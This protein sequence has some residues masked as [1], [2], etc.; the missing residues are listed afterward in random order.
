M[1]Y[2]DKMTLKMV[3][4]VQWNGKNIY[5]ISRFVCVSVTNLTP[6]LKN[7]VQILMKNRI[8]I[9]P[10]NWYV[11]RYFGEQSAKAEVLSEDEFKKTYEEDI[12]LW[13]LKKR[14]N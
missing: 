6:A 1:M 11:V 7:G 4:A 2:R 9:I 8:L 10:K 5:E 14:L 3:E 13:N 12:E